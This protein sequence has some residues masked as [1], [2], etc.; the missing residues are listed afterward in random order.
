MPF[1]SFRGRP[2]VAAL[3]AGALAWPWP[4][5]AL[6]L[7][8]A[9][10]LAEREAP[11]LAAQAASQQAAR[12]AAIP[13][14]ELP[15]PKLT[16]GVQNLPIEEDDRWSVNR[17]SMSMRM[18]GVMQEMT[19]GD[20][21]QARVEVAQAG[22]EVADAEQRIALLTVRR[23]TALAWIANLAVERKLALFQELY[24]EN[25]LFER[26]VR[27]RIAGGKGLAADAVLPRQ[28]KALLDEQ[29]DEL[30]Q[31]RSSARAALRRWIGAAAGQVLQ[32]DW[33][34]WPTDTAH[35]Q[36]NL[37]RHPELAVFAPQTRQAEARVRE[38]IA[39]KKP[40]WGWEL[41]YLKR[42]NHYSDM[43][44][45]K[46]TFD[47]PLFTGSRQDP[48]IAVERARVTQLEAEREAR[49]REHTWALEDELAGYQRL[50][51]A[52]KRL[53]QT[54]LPLAEEKVRLAL[55]DYSGGKGSLEAV[56]EARQE[57]IR[58]CLRRIDLAEQ[59][60]ASG[61]GLHF[62]FGDIEP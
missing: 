22:I 9:L 42:G 53:D 29:Q 1:R 47:L 39:A 52:L 62:A 56:V 18:I 46:F 28:E 26:T 34:R 45:L 20:K 57:R 8:E 21:R 60:A 27:A 43:V 5:A 38:A 59:Y 19:N 58:T 13:A 25:R 41:D 2:C 24:T 32:G 54:L 48:K 61:A 14:G 33:P 50:D 10:R 55:A 15:D 35:Y 30:Q 11:T 37:Q 4:A 3:L 36:H 16:L 31:A 44:N 23:Q 6:T 40:D 51:Q 49:V 17:D 12:S 7:D